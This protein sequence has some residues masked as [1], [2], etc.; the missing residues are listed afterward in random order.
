VLLV[1]V[2]GILRRERLELNA[3]TALCGLFRSDIS[4]EHTTGCE[5]GYR[6]LLLAP[7]AFLAA[8]TF[9]VPGAFLFAVPLVLESVMAVSLQR[10][11]DWR[12]VG[13]GTAIMLGLALLDLAVRQTARL[14]RIR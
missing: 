1:Y 9:L 11:I 8:R 5:M 12:W 13:T 2:D 3:G 14:A 10:T 7:V 6:V 4:V